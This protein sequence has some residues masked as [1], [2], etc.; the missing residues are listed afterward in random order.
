LGNLGDETDLLL[1]VI[2]AVFETLGNLMQQKNGIKAQK[3]GSKT[4]SDV[5]SWQGPRLTSL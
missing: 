3:V 4:Y 1:A 5:F 2:F